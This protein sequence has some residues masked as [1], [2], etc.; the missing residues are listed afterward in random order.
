[1][2]PDVNPDDR[3]VGQQRVLVRCR[4]NL[5]LL[6]LKV[7]SEP[8]PARALDARSGG[9]ELLLEVVEGAEALLD[10]LLEGTVLEST[11]VALALGG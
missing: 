4:H 5:Q 8:A 7:V 1:M 3:D 10:G 9:V 6:R 11:A 2:L